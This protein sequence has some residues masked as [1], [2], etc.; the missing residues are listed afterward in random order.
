MPARTFRCPKCSQ[1]I[2]VH[3]PVTMSPRCTRHATNRSVEMV[4]VE[5]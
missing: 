3:L 2:T 4:E 5:K 1:T